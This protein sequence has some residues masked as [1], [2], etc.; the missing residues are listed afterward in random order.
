M[1]Q[2]CAAA[3]C[4]LS[5]DSN[6]F[7]IH[8]MGKGWLGFG[9]IDCGV[10][11]SIHNQGGSILRDTLRE[12]FPLTRV[13]QIIIG[14]TQCLHGPQRGQRIHQRVAYLTIATQDHGA[15]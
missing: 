7:G 12:G 8:L 15:H 9:P 10:C 11:R 4:G 1:D 14:A 13:G 6:R 2:A 3:L 5:N